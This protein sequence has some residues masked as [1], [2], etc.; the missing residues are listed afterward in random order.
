MVQHAKKPMPALELKVQCLYSKS[1]IKRLKQ[2]CRITFSGTPEP[3]TWN[4]FQN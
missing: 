2:L 1:E 3:V 4:M